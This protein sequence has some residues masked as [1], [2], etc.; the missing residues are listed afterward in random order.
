MINSQYFILLI[1]LAPQE[2]M[3]NQIAR[4]V[5]GYPSGQDGAILA[6]RDYPLY[7]TSKLSPK[8]INN[9]CFIDQVCSVKM[10]G[11]SGLVLF[12]RVYGPRRSINVINYVLP[13]SYKFQGIL[14]QGLQVNW[15]LMKSIQCSY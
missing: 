1:W 5:F 6:A 7:P 8:A 9:K 11:Y 13:C 14:I 10:D 2:G 15:M 12:S 4:A 3:M